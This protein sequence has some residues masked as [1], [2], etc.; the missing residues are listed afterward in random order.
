MEYKLS[1]KLGNAVVD[2]LKTRPYIEVYG[3]MEGL[4]KLP[5]I[6]NEEPVEESDKQ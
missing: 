1:E 5:I 2:Y 6:P 3:L 4:L